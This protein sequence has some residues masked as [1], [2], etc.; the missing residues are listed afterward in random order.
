MTG[1][2]LRRRMALEQPARSPDG[3]GGFVETWESLGEVWVEVRALQG[4][5][6]TQG[7]Q[8]LSRNAHRMVLRAA[9]QGSAMRPRPDQRLREGARIFTILAVSDSDPAGRYLTC[10][11]Q[12]EVAP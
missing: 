8:T 9:P 2:H 5:E 4:R 3:A 12:E 6:V 11:T 10:F 1:V 7:G